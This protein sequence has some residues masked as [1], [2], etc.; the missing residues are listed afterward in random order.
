MANLQRQLLRREKQL[1]RQ[2]QP[3]RILPP[4]EHLDFPVPLRH[5][6]GRRRPGQSLGSRALPRRLQLDTITSPQTSLP[7][8]HAAFPSSA[9]PAPC[10]LALASPSPIL[11]PA[12]SSDGLTSCYSC[13]CGALSGRVCSTSRSCCAP[14]DRSAC[15]SWVMRVSRMSDTRMCLHVR[16][17]GALWAE[18]SGGC[19]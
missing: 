8:P 9:P 1:S 3:H 17:C 12:S 6:R 15:V 4:E 16:V 19:W 5:R 11:S 2:H 13:T 14:A 7:S 18:E 10:I